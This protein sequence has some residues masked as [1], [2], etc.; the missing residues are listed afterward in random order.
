MSYETEGETR[1]VRIEKYVD[2]AITPV[3]GKEEGGNVVDPQQ[4]ILGRTRHH[5]I[6]LRQIALPRFRT[7]LE[8]RRPLGRNR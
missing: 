7:Q 1:I 5:R 6:A 4:P 3:R 8:S 2:G